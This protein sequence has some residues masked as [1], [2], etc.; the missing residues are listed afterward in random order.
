MFPWIVEWLLIALA[1]GI[2]WFI[3]HRQS[4]GGPREPGSSSKKLPR[5][6]EVVFDAYDSPTLDSF[7]QTL[8]INAETVKLHLSLAGYFR[9]RGEIEKSTAIHQ[10][11][12]SHPESGEA[13]TCR[14]TFELGQDYMAGGLYDRAEDL[15][16]KLIQSGE[17]RDASIE[18]LLEIYEHEKDWD[19]ARD[20]ALSLDLKRNR[21]VQIRV[22]HYCCEMAERSLR[23]K[24]HEEARA[25]LKEA[26]GY[27]KRCVRAS[28]LLGRIH[29]LQGQH[30]EA[31][32][33][34]KRIE[35]Q[36]PAFLV[37]ALEM[38]EE[39]CTPDEDDG[40]YARILQ[41]IWQLHPSSRVMTAL[42]LAKSKPEDNRAS[43]EFLLAQLDEHPTL[44]GVK[45]LLSLLLP[46][47]DTEPKRWIQIVRGVLDSLLEKN[48][49]YCCKNCG[50][51]GKHLHW[52]C[53][54]CKSWST[55]EPVPWL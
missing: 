13:F 30:A 50:F 20:R 54:S 55:V 46:F 44:G 29:L 41:R 18:R 8:P 34:L 33:E 38:I 36:D 32:T 23:R 45:T 10:K 39:A 19:I 37:E 43:I 26:L 25:L 47:A 22:A 7:I 51:S 14:I 1:V 35:Q 49:S 21:R 3:G 27:D 2:G 5:A 6:F 16:Q 15:F 12:L 48:E 42:A 4:R 40:K 52:Q 24:A 17:W 11:L 31:L 28:L 53:P 9:R